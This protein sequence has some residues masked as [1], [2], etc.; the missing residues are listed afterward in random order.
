MCM[1]C[2]LLFVLFYFF[3]W[4]L[5]CLFF[6]D[7][8][9]LITPLIPSNSSYYVPMQSIPISPLM[10]WVR[11]TIR[12][13]CTKLSDKVCQWFATGRWF[14]PGSLVPPPTVRHEITETNLLSFEK[15]ILPGSLTCIHVS[16]CIFV[17]KEMNEN[18]R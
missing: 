17:T 2:R 9:I 16:N 8:R 7:I 4:L 10:L 6:F 15:C 13:R 11:I 12:T 5:C 1:F 3:F 14:S 18:R